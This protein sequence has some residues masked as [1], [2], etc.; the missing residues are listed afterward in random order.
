MRG[1][2]LTVVLIVVIVEIVVV[3]IVVVGESG[4]A[5]VKDSFG[6]QVTEFHDCYTSLPPSRELI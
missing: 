1:V 6:G 5:G 3:E 2:V 4:R